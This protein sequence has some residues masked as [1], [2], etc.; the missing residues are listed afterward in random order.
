MLDSMSSANGVK[1]VNIRV[2]RDG[3]SPAEIKVKKGKSI[4][5]A[6]F[7]EDNHDC[8][9]EVVFPS[10]LSGE[11]CRSEKQ[12]LFRSP[13]VKQECCPSSVIGHVQRDAHGCRPGGI[14]P[15]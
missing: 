6:F 1:T 11:A 13:L 10:L 2:S 3:H 5:L 14:E 12:R 7:R 15:H 8:G 4:N 9:D